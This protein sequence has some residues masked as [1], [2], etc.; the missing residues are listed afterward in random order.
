MFN[1]IFI[2]NEENKCTFDNCGRFISRIRLRLISPVARR[3]HRVKG[4]G[5]AECAAQRYATHNFDLLSKQR[6][7][8]HTTAAKVS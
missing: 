5:W 1:A 6:A 2:S 7:S 8:A 3:E 4:R